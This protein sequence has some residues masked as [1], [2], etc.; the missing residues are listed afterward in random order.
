VGRGAQ[1]PKAQLWIIPLPPVYARSAAKGA[2]SCRAVALAKGGRFS[3]VAHQGGDPR[4][5]KPISNDGQVPIFLQSKLGPMSSAKFRR[6]ERE[7]ESRGVAGMLTRYFS[8]ETLIGCV[9]RSNRGGKIDIKPARESFRGRF[10]FS[11]AALSA[12][13]RSLTK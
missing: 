6:K 2:G 5:A 12:A 10:Y 4:L 11:P 7:I 9:V 8:E 3:S 13:R 1:G